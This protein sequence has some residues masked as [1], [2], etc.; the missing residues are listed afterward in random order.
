MAS[1]NAGD[2][3]NDD[4]GLDRRQGFGAGNSGRL[5]KPCGVHSLG[6][7]PFSI[8]PLKCIVDAAHI[9]LS[10]SESSLSATDVMVSSILVAEYASLTLA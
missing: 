8:R 3:L 4:F 10:F 5:G 9:S 2:I 6:G 7:F 1:T